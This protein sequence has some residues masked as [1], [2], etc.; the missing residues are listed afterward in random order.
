VISLLYQDVFGDDDVHI[1]NVAPIS[2][3]HELVLG[4]VLSCCGKKYQRRRLV[5]NRACI[6]RPAVIV[7]QK[8]QQ[9]M[10]PLLSILP[11]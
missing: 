1:K 10:L 4:E 7:R 5:N 9:K 8:K 2:R 6:A 11:R 3:L